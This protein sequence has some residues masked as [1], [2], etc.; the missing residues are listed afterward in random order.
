MIGFRENMIGKK[1]KTL[2]I[3]KPLP[4]RPYPFMTPIP[5]LSGICKVR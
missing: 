5:S 2:S 1:R 4:L 3:E